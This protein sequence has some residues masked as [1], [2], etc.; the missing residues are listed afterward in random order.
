MAEKEDPKTE[1]VES[2]S[3]HKGVHGAVVNPLESTEEIPWDDK[4]QVPIAEELDC[5]TE[6]DKRQ[7]AQ[8]QEF[9][10]QRALKA[11]PVKK[12]DPPKKV[13]VKT[14]AENQVDQW[15]ARKKNKGVAVPGFD[16]SGA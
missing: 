6:V 1:V 8:Q 15:L 12:E 3:T 10:R 9:F 2:K 7:D 13:V 11:A 14:E 16:E 5:R 4:V